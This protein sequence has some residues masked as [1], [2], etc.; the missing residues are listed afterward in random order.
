MQGTFLFRPKNEGSVQDPVPGTVLGTILESMI[1]VLMVTIKYQNKERKERIKPK[2][3][4]ELV[5]PVYICFV[6]DFNVMY[7]I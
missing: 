2:G 4:Q 3:L 7:V 6:Y 1:V 5:K